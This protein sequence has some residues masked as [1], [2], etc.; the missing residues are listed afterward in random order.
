[1]DQEVDEKKASVS[2][3]KQ[4]QFVSVAGISL[5]MFSLFLTF[6]VVEISL[7]FRDLPQM[8]YEL[9]G[10]SMELDRQLLYR[11]VPHSGFDINGAGYR[12]REF[13][14]KKSNEKRI[15]IFGDSILMSLNLPLENTIPRFLQMDLGRS[16]QI[17]NMGVH[18]YGPDQELL[19]LRKEG[20]SLEPDLVL[21]VLYPANDFN[22]L[23]KNRLIYENENGALQWSRKNPL[24]EMLP[25]LRLWLLV[26]GA[27]SGRYLDKTKEMDLF[28]RMFQ[29][30]YDVDL[31][32]APSSASS[33]TKTKL[34]Q[35]VLRNWKQDLETKG[36]P[37]GVIIVPSV[38]SIQDHVPL[39]K[40]GIPPDQYFT[41][42]KLAEQA[43][44]VE[45]IPLLDL[46]DPFLS[47]SEKTLYDSV[48]RH[49]NAT[50][51]RYA[52]SLIK[53]F[54]LSRLKN[55]Q[56]LPNNSMQRTTAVQRITR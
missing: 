16:Y 12:E 27:I 17:F 43:C 25:A 29:D 13:T 48:D 44:A 45:R 3:K 23:Y 7:R 18:G 50:G 34:M 38:E 35:L 33:D 19:R 8:R 24:S 30:R 22:D 5:I 4:I 46:T 10:M 51:C 36:I 55:N 49:L 56:A 32:L 20:F 6:G 39:E 26:R 2:G 37:F 31:T 14:K 54:L 53:P 47:S 42:E 28:V 9:F 40:A 15:L 52:A 1:M 41:L 21:L 11:V